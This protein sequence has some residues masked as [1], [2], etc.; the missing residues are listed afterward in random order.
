MAPKP[1]RPSRAQSL[2]GLAWLLPSARHDLR[3]PKVARGWREDFVMSTV[4]M[5]ATAV[6][7]GRKDSRRTGQP[8]SLDQR[9]THKGSGGCKSWIT[10][11]T[12]T[13]ARFSSLKSMHTT[14]SKHRSRPPSAILAPRIA[15]GVSMLCSFAYREAHSEPIL[16]TSRELARSWAGPHAEKSADG[17]VV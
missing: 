7:I 13:V 2:E 10:V 4:V 11:E 9:L 8:N 1:K 5:L 3:D 6:V 14:S 16:S 17:V 12:T 15:I